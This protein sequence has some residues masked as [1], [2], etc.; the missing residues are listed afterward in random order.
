[1]GEIRP[2]VAQ[3]VGAVYLNQSENWIYHQVRHLEQHRSIFLAK[4]TANL[5]LFPWEPVYSLR[6]LGRA[7]RQWNRFARNLLGYFPLFASACRREGV[8]LLHAHNGLNGM[9]AVR[10]AR[11]LGVPLVTSFYGRD[12]YFHPSGEAGLRRAYRSLFARGTAFIVEGP[13][14]GAKLVRL[15]CPPERIHI[16]RLGV[17]PDTIE[18]LPRAPVGDEPLK[19]LMAARFVEKKGFPY[20]VEAFC[21]VAREEPRL[22]LTI[23][24]DAGEA[25]A[26][27]RIRER[28]QALV[29]DY[30]VADQVSHIGFVT[31]PSLHELAREHHLFLHPSVQASDGDAEGGHPVVLT[32]MAAAGM[33]IIATRHCDIPEVVIDGETGW[34]CAERSVDDIAAALR[35]AVSRPE[36]LLARGRRARRLVESKYD[37]RS[38]TLDGIYGEVLAG[39]WKPHGG[40]VSTTGRCQSRVLV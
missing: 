6:Q 12:M 28:L 19:V 13:A 31:R 27:V 5:E 16:H 17:E 15:G 2:T 9:R 35:E 26:E 39:S 4:R 33:P 36:L 7:R 29:Q 18:F 8:R 11:I 21:R 3:D 24:G 22:R 40:G 10:L 37:L 25:P 34:L 32:E 20:G 30:Q 14:A 1:M 38:Q 23:V